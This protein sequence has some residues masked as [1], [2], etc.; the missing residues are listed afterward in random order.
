MDQ[1][2]DA[3]I[4]SPGP[5][6]VS[7]RRA[8]QLTGG[9][10]VGAL[11]ASPTTAIAA[12]PAVTT[13]DATDSPGSATV[14]EGTNFMVAV[15]P[16]GRLLA[17]DLVTAIWVLDANGGTARR[18]TD[19]LQDATRPRWS[20]DGSRLVFQSYRDGNFHLWTIG[21]DGSGLRQVT[22]GRYD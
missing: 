21:P 17:F 8:L 4:E 18:L 13:T 10:A 11:A 20:P 1:H 14:A 2:D 9:L 6:S 5:W 7:R 3:T 16:D 12:T 19:D 22:S 15:S